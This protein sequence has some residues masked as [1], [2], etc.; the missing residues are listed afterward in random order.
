MDLSNLA[1]SQLL[2]QNPS[3]FGNSVVRKKVH[4]QTLQ[5]GFL[6]I[7]ERLVL[8]RRRMSKVGWLVRD[9]L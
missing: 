3:L 6:K 7:L 4:K 1:G 8:N 5:A 2:R 9:E